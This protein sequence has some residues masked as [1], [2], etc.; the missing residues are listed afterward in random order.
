MKC[1]ECDFYYSDWSKGHEEASP[2]C[3]WLARTA[4]DVPPCEDDGGMKY[5]SSDCKYTVEYYGYIFWDDKQVGWNFFE[6]DSFE[7][8]IEFYDAYHDDG[9]E[10]RIIDNEYDV[11]FAD[12]E[13][14]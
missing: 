5:G 13:W 7:K 8:A 11:V 4:W 6:T 10:I 2:Y 1:S 12:G 9:L 14:S 3:H